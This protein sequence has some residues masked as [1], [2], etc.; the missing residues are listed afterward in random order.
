MSRQPDLSP[1]EAEEVRRLYREDNATWSMMA[2]AR[3]FNCNPATIR[4]VV[5]RH[6][7]YRAK[8]SKPGEKR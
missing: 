8:P 1:E 3:A 6:G 4:A 2:L 5:Y 7:A